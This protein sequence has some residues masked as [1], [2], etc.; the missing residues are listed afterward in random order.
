MGVTDLNLYV[1]YSGKYPNILA[2]Y[3]ASKS[4]TTAFAISYVGFR[5]PS[6]ISQ[7]RLELDTQVSVLIAFPSSFVE[8]RKVLMTCG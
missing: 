5:V 3:C 7:N 1:Y 8:F 2:D 6:G 4:C